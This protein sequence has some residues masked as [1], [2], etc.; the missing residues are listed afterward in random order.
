MQNY[1]DSEAYFERW[2]WFLKLESDAERERLASRR[3]TRKA[4]GMSDRSM[5][6]QGD[7]L[8]HMV[9]AD[10]RTGLGGRTIVNFVKRERNQILPWNR[11]RVG[12]PVVA[13]DE[14]DKRKGK[15][16]GRPA[17]TIVFAY[18]SDPADGHQEHELFV[19]V[20]V[21]SAEELGDGDPPERAVG[22]ERL[23][24][25]G[26]LRF[27]GSLLHRWDESFSSGI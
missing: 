19:E 1:R 16:Q 24:V 14:Q 5:E 20:V 27:V 18:R 23:G 12:S 6:A 17:L 15:S 8:M 11:F 13:S 3:A 25:K 21:E 10:D 4:R 9:I 7:T 2:S 26:F 22:Q